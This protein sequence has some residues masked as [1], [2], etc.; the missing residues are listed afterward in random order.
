L[1][2]RNAAGD[3]EANEALVSNK[4]IDCPLAAV[5]AVLVDLEPLEASNIG[6]SCVGHLRTGDTT[7][8]SEAKNVSYR[9]DLQVSHDRALVRGVDGV[10]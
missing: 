1:T 2:S 6:L 5:K 10:L 9:R 7:E 4:F 3:C 8:W